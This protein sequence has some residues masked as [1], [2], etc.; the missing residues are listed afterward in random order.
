MNPHTP[1]SDED[2]LVLDDDGPGDGDLE[3]GSA[4]SVTYPF[5]GNA[6]VLLDEHAVQRVGAVGALGVP[7]N[8]AGNTA[9]RAPGAKTPKPA[10]GSDA[11]GGGAADDPLSALVK[12]KRKKN[13]LIKVRI[14]CI[15]AMEGW[16]FEP[17]SPRSL[18]HRCPLPSL[19]PPRR[20]RRT[21]WRS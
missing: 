17:L 1:L 6:S 5:S 7:R 3:E 9:V 13:I 4:L 15:H 16:P 8:E 11:G 18:P 10:L 14:A 20:R 12:V 21:T 19:P 2:E